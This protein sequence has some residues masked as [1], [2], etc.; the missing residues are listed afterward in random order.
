MEYE[1]TLRGL[2]KGDFTAAQ[3]GIRRAAAKG[4]RP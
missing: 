1:D 4:K 3:R 2:R